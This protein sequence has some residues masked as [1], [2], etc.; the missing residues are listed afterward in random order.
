M[1]EKFKSGDKYKLREI[2]EILGFS[3]PTPKN[4]P[5]N[6]RKAIYRELERY[7]TYH[8]EGTGKGQ[9]VVIDEVFLTIHDK[10]DGR[11]QGNNSK[12]I[13]DLKLIILA[14]IECGSSSLESRR[15]L[16]TDCFN[17]F[18][19]KQYSAMYD[20]SEDSKAVEL[21][22]STLF[23]KLKSALDNALNRLERN[24]KIEYEKQKMIPNALNLGLLSK[25]IDSGVPFEEVLLKEV[26][27]ISED[28]IKRFYLLELD[29]VKL[30]DFIF[31]KKGTE[32]FKLTYDNT[33]Q[34]LDEVEMLQ[35]QYLNQK[36]RFRIE[37]FQYNKKDNKYHAQSDDEEKAI[38]YI[39][40]GIREYFYISPRD[41]IG[42]KRKLF[43]QNLRKVYEFFGSGAYHW[44]AYKIQLIVDNTEYSTNDKSLSIAHFKEKVS[45]AMVEYVKNR[46]KPPRPRYGE[47]GK[48]H[49]I[50]QD[51]P[52]VCELHKR[53]FGKELI[54]TTKDR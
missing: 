21:Y 46:I 38:K 29:S 25:A 42:K 45:D 49:S 9:I 33:N 31:D 12:Y 41:S 53:I 18:E 5:T 36:E 7:C 15:S 8:K 40:S 10:K 17:I 37:Y 51:F 27:F 52:D 34:K 47:F 11:A 30:I 4:I 2:A 44:D 24:K 6:T 35:E 19:E 32:Y 50:E 3:L 13:D 16:Y 1:M 22:K 26:F 20:D 39:E 48:K 54:D 28:D 23:N 43:R 14:S